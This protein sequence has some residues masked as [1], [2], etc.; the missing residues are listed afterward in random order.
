MLRPFNTVPHVLVTPPTIKL[1]LLVLH[2][3]KFATAMNCNVNIWVFQW[4]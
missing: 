2:S 4:S 1:F 3:Y